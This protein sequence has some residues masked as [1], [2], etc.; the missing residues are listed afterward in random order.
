MAVECPLIISPVELQELIGKPEIVIV[1]L[2]GAENYRQS[3][4]PGA[5][6]LEYDRLTRSRPPLLGLLP[7]R[8][9]LNQVLTELGITPKKHVIAYD[10]NGGDT[11]CRLLWILDLIGHSRYSLLDGGLPAWIN[12]G[13]PVNNDIP[14]V[15]HSDYKVKYN[16]HAIA[17]KHYILCHLAD[18][19]VVLLDTRSEAEYLGKIERTRRSGHIPGAVH[20]DWSRSLDQHNNNHIRPEQE[21]RP[22]FEVLGLTPDKEI[23]TYCQTHR[24]AAHTYFILKTLGYPHVRGY[25]GSWEE[26]GNCDNTPIEIA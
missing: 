10:N 1:D 11:A 16:D 24:R 21:L 17:T 18:P 2:A 26:W 12:E 19:N 13:H 5:L 22:L 6:H 8:S 3:H 14:E 25:P 20:L 4:I 9:D 15:M 7:E 23:I